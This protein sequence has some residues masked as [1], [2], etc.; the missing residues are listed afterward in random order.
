[1]SYLKNKK[2]FGIIGTIVGIAIT[3]ALITAFITLNL[4]TLKTSQTNSKELKALLYAKELIEI[5]KELEQ[6]NW[7]EISVLSNEDNCRKPFYPIATGTSL[8]W[9]INSNNSE[10]EKLENEFYYRWIIIENVFRASTTNKIFSTGCTETNTETYN[11]P[12]TK[13]ITA[14]VEW[15]KNSTT[16]TTT[17]ESY[18]YNYQ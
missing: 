18:L 17:L 15:N 16:S 7:N 5:G 1:M 13:K 3:G 14:I 9:E 4:S 2:G 8:A 6:S 11:D 10:I 12:N